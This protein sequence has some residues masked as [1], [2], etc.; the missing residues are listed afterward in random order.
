MAKLKILWLTLNASSAV[1]L[2]DPGNTR[3]GWLS[4]LEKELSHHNDIELHIGFYHGVRLHSFE[5]GQTTFHPLFRFARKNKFT[6]F[7]RRIHAGRNNDQRDIEN[8]RILIDQLQPDI[9]HIH[10]TE[11]NFGTIQEFTSI[12]V[13]IS[14]QGLLN[15]Y[16][17]KYF[18]GIPL[19][20]T[21][22]FL[23]L[24]DRLAFR[25]AKTSYKKMTAAAEREKQILQ[26]ARYII[27]RT[28]WD[29]NFTRLI[30]PNSIYF[31]GQEML[32]PSFYSKEWH[33]N[34]P[35]GTLKIVTVSS[36]SLYK[37][38]EMIVKTARLLKEYSD[39]DYIWVVAGLNNSSNCVKVVLKWLDADL[40]SLGIR[41][42]GNQ[43]ETQLA[44]LLATSDIFCQV[45]HIENSPNS[46]CEAQLIGIPIIATDVGGTNTLI[47]NGDSGILCQEGE[48]FSMA[49]YIVFA[50]RNFMQCKIMAGK[51]R[52]IA[53]IRH[54]QTEIKNQY[55][56]IY[57]KIISYK[58]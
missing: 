18:S 52:K 13:V 31:T 30:A 20:V 4:S 8:I 35:N 29:K 41:L 42:I 24:V 27:G 22:R 38:F 28:D 5:H 46:L 54:N 25:S 1:E 7:L 37:G 57:K 51:G 6:R 34:P 26:N 45:S 11:E 44:D 53:L 43:T 39:L 16:I 23:S 47:Q 19:N 33:Q 12:P 50:A 36:D 32:R 56:D 55:I 14:L 2:L 9:I 3:C 21:R 40:E 15:P 10:G 17:E 49:G 58:Y 48:P